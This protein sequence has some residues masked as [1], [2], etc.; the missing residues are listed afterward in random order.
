MNGTGG[1]YSEKRQSENNLRSYSVNN[2]FADESLDELS[3]LKQRCAD[4]EQ[5]KNELLEQIESNKIK[6]R[7]LLIKKD[8]QILK[9]KMVLGKLENELKLGESAM[10]PEDIFKVA[11]LS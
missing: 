9:F 6:A 7:N 1:P 5:I 4:F 10:S 11:Q 8:V 2:D 3:L